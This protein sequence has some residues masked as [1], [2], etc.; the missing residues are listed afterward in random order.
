MPEFLTT[1]GTTHQLEQ[2]IQDTDRRLTLISPYLQF[3]NNDLARLKAADNRGVETHLVLRTEKLRSEEQEKLRGFKNLSLYTLDNLHAKCYANEKCILISSMNLY[4]YSEANNWEMG[5]LLTDADGKAMIDARREI[6]AILQA[7]T[8]RPMPGMIRSLIAN[9]FQRP[10]VS[11]TKKAVAPKKHEGFCIR[12]SDE[13]RYRP[14]SPLCGSCYSSWAAWENENYPE[15]N[16]HR[17]GN[18]ADVTKA[19][20]LCTSCFRAAPFTPVS[21]SF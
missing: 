14:V 12:C 11:P 1:R 17:C 16:C 21:R 10:P 7:S 3:S 4:S 5:V 8:Q 18:S 13:I 15:R 9:V 2:L 19:K 20:P 6:N